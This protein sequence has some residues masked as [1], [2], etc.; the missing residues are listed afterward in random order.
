M[1]LNPPFFSSKYGAEIWI[2]IILPAFDSAK[3]T[4]FTP[5]CAM[6]KPWLRQEFARLL[7]HLDPKRFSDP[8]KLQ[9]VDLAGEFGS[10]DAMSHLEEWWKNNGATW[11][12]PSFKL[13]YKH[14]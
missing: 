1:V 13:L 14:Q 8:K 6:K 12:P 4:I 7:M 10:G 11:A 3:S 2:T 9:L 5:S